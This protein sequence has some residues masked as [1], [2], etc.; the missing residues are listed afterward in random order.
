MGTPPNPPPAWGAQR[1]LWHTARGIQQRLKGFFFLIGEERLTLAH[2]GV[3]LGMD[4][5]NLLL[6]VKGE[7]S[8]TG[9]DE[10]C[11]CVTKWR[12]R[13]R[14]GKAP[15]ELS[16]PLKARIL[17]SYTVGTGDAWAGRM[18]ILWTGYFWEDRT[19]LPPDF[20]SLA[21]INAGIKLQSWEIP[22]IMVFLE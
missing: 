12:W 9:M 14:E 19:F 20:L 18:T 17:S 15:L 7:W 1:W 13:N 11:L 5:S 6:V 16:I 22:P 3:Q 4:F 10:I 8:H 2:K 21:S